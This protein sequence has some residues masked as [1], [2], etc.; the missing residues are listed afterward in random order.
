[1]D[2]NSVSVKLPPYDKNGKGTPVKGISPNN[3]PKLIKIC[4]KIN[5]ATPRQMYLF[6]I[7]CVILDIL[8]I[9]NK[10]MI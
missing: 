5:V 6:L 4:I 9:R 1:M 3:P 7:V 2:I 8:N 10:I